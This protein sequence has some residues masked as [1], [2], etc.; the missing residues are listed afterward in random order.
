[1]KKIIIFGNSLVVQC[2]PT[3]LSL[4]RTDTD[5]PN[6]IYLFFYIFQVISEYCRTRL[7][8]KP[9]THIVM[10]M[11]REVVKSPQY[12]ARKRITYQHLNPVPPLRNPSD[13]TEHNHRQTNYPHQ[14]HH[15]QQPSQQSD[16]LQSMHSQ[17]KNLHQQ[18]DRQYR[19][20]NQYN[21]PRPSQQR[22]P[23]RYQP[24][25]HLQIQEVPQQVHI[26]KVHHYHHHHHP[27]KG[28]LF[29]LQSRN[30]HSHPNLT[31]LCGQ[32]LQP[33]RRQEAEDQR[34]QFQSQLNVQTSGRSVGPA[35]QH[36][37]RHHHSRTYSQP[38]YTRL[39]HTRSSG[40]LASTI[41]SESNPG[42]N[43]YSDPIYA[44]PVKPFL[45]S[46]DVRVN[47]LSVKPPVG[48]RNEDVYTATTIAR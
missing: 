6:Y 46:Q 40:N 31:S 15:H 5:Y 20:T 8:S 30:S 4:Y 9:F 24:H 47:G 21:P 35:I 18:Q 48:H 22:S 39:Q 7:Q 14:H 36:Q 3:S 27:A 38:I 1:M 2:N 11:Y 29:K 43:V 28:A 19:S 37:R 17:A 12:T 41:V 32:Q 10:D 45:S 33:N 42:G 16:P 25:Q 44:L 23:T 26:P 13:L 34:T